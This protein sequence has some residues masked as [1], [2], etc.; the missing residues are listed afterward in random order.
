MLTWSIGW[1]ILGGFDRMRLRLPAQEDMSSSLSEKEEEVSTTIV[2]NRRADGR[3]QVRIGV[4][5]Y[6]GGMSFGSVS[7]NT[8]LSRARAAEAWDTFTCTGEGVFLNLYE[9]TMTT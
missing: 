3:P 8:M 1:A 5:F 2:L 9:G 4:P 7:I 6:G